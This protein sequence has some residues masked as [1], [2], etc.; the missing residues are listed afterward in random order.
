MGRAAWPS[1][2]KAS[3]SQ[4]LATGSQVMKK[5]PGAVLQA[6]KALKK[7]PGVCHAHLCIGMGVGGQR[8]AHAPWGMFPAYC[9]RFVF[10][11][12]FIS[13]LVYFSLKRGCYAKSRT[14][15]SCECVILQLLPGCFCELDNNERNINKQ[16]LSGLAERPRSCTCRLPKGGVPSLPCPHFYLPPPSHKSHQTQEQGWEEQGSRSPGPKMF[17]PPE[18]QSPTHGCPPH[19]PLYKSKQKPGLIMGYFPSPVANGSR[20]CVTFC[21]LSFIILAFYLLLPRAPG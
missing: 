2:D 6:A 16:R 14:R 8:H 18:G 21:S 1:K 3:P 5:G 10:L 11:P 17:A 9:C 12:T 15:I 13:G 20:A 7:E 4:N 19:P